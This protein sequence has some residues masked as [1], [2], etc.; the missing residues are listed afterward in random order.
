MPDDVEELLTWLKARRR[1]YRQQAQVAVR[2]QREAVVKLRRLGVPFEVIRDQADVPTGT[3]HR[4]ARQ[5]ETQTMG[6]EQG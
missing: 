2:E 5:Y 6:E 3:A 1:G 4:W